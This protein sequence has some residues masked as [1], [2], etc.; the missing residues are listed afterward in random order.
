MVRSVRQAR[1]VSLFVS[2]SGAVRCNG[3]S[4]GVITTV[5]WCGPDSAVGLPSSGEQRYLALSSECVTIH[6][7]VDDLLDFA[8]DMEPHPAL[9]AWCDLR[10]NV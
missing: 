1:P 5:E 7:E 8:S 4:W 2:R 3:Y 6:E 10:D 9:I